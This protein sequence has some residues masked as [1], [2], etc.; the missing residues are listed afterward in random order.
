MAAAGSKP[1]SDMSSSGSV[2]SAQSHEPSHE[3][4][5]RASSSRASRLAGVSLMSAA[6]GMDAGVSSTRSDASEP[7]PFPLA[8]LPPVGMPFGSRLLS[9]ASVMTGSF[10]LSMPSGR[11]ACGHTSSS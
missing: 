5:V 9:F 11:T 6:S 3:L 10:P 4:M 8:N 1:S 7:P 2:A